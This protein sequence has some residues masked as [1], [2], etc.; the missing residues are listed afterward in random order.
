MGNAVDTEATGS[1]DG[2]GYFDLVGEAEDGHVDTETRREIA[3]AGGRVG[4]SGRVR[5][6]KADMKLLLHTANRQST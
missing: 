3:A 6:W 5:G 4:Y 2:G 1:G